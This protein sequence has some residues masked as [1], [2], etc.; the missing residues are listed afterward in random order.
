MP[1]TTSLAQ[2]LQSLVPLRVKMVENDPGSL[3]LI[4]ERWSLAVLGEWVWRRDGV[5][6]TGRDQPESDDTTWDLSGLD[7]TGATFPDPSSTGDC[8]FSLSDGVL[9]VRSDRT[10]WETWTFH[11]DD[12]DVIFVGL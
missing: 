1:D 12:L 8:I 6:V 4:G 11:H 5:L 3:V 7:L 2:A 10:G 9:E